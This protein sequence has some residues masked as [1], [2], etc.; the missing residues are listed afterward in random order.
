LGAVPWL[1]EGVVEGD[2]AW[3]VDDAAD[4]GSAS[5]MV[6]DN[7]RA[8]VLNVFTIFKVVLRF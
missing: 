6:A 5:A 8:A 7:R 1:A 2:V 3:G 4:C